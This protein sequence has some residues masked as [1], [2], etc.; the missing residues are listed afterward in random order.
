MKCLGFLFK[1]IWFLQTNL[2]SSQET[3]VL[4]NFYLKHKTYKSFD[5]G[6]EVKGVFLD[7]SKAFDKVKRKGIIFKLKENGIPVNYLVHYLTFY[8][9]GNRGLF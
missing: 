9:I 7:I 8:K 6:F 5:D 2:L 1:T 4:T 3:P